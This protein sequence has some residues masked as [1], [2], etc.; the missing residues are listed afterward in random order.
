L[1][2]A[3]LHNAAKLHAI[4]QKPACDVSQTAALQPAGSVNPAAVIAGQLRLSQFLPVYVGGPIF[5]NDFLLGCL[6][7]RIGK[8]QV[9]MCMC[10]FEEILRYYKTLDIVELVKL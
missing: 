10:S 8:T 1:I 7:T 5:V 4:G 2:V 6:I 3:A 9:Y